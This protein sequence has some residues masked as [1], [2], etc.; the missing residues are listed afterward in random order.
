VNRDHSDDDQL[1][2]M[3]MAEYSLVIVMDTKWTHAVFWLWA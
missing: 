1:H 3:I 2:L